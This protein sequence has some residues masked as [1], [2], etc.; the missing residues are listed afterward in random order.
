VP[1]FLRACDVGLIFRENNL[2]NSV[3]FPTKFGEYLSSGLFVIST[4]V[5]KE[6]DR[7]VQTYKNVGFIIKSFPDFDNKEIR[8][9]I[10]LLEN[11]DLLSHGN[12]MCRYR[13]AMENIATDLQY[14][15][16]EKIYRLLAQEV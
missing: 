12:R 15:K 11:G 2:L 13:I 4:K 3:S 10:S 5:P 14:L 6:I 9:I 16:Y 7:F 8:T 1:Q